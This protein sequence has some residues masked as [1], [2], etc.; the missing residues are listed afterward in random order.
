[1]LWSALRGS[2]QVLVRSEA[3]LG[4]HPVEGNSSWTFPF[5]TPDFKV[6]TRG[7]GCGRSATYSTHPQH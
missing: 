2:V 6:C 3:L 1:M 5:L 4:P 7:E